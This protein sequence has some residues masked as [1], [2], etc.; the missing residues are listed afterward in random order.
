MAMVLLLKTCSD[1]QLDIEE[2]VH[3]PIHLIKKFLIN[4]LRAITNFQSFS[5][6]ISNEKFE[7]EKLLLL[8]GKL[9]SCV[10]FTLIVLLPA[11]V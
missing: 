1:L 10:A 7:N 11:L 4:F 9:S 6:T 3:L 5:I 2:S 8:Q